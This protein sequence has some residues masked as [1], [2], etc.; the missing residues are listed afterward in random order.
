M[1]PLENAKKELV[2]E[3]ERMH[4]ATQMLMLAL[5]K[6]IKKDGELIN[7]QGAQNTS[8]IAGTV[9]NV[10]VILREMNLDLNIL[11]LKAFKPEELP[12]IPDAESEAMDAFI[13]THSL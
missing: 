4:N 10:G 6:C 11:E 8:Y 13:K 3:M 7:T 2:D 9:Q 12:L 5:G 1:E